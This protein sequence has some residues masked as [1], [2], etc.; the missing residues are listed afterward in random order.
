MQNTLCAAR[1][2]RCSCSASATICTVRTVRTAARARSRPC[3]SSTAY[4]HACHAQQDASRDAHSW[5]KWPIAIRPETVTPSRGTTG[6]RTCRENDPRRLARGLPDE[7]H[8][9]VARFSSAYRPEQCSDFHD[10]DS[11]Y[12]DLGRAAATAPTSNANAIAQRTLKQ[13]TSPKDTPGTVWSAASA[14]AASMSTS[15]IPRATRPP[16]ISANAS[17]RESAAGAGHPPRP[18]ADRQQQAHAPRG[19]ARRL[20]DCIRR[21]PPRRSLGQEWDVMYVP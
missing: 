20:T 14:C 17:D 18:H 13:H 11:I 8:A 10:A 1:K 15:C 19:P 16:S 21:R 4:W 5:L 9:Y 12:A 6:H 2:R 7:L 3:P